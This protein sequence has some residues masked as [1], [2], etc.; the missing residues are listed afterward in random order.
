MSHEEIEIEVDKMG[1]VTI[2]T[3]GIKGDH[4]FRTLRDRGPYR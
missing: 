4:D 3:R 1:K 2:R